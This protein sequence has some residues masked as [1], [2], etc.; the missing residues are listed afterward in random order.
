MRLSTV[1]VV[2]LPQ[3]S[4]SGF[5]P[6][7]P[8]RCIFRIAPACLE[9]PPGSASPPRSTVN[10]H[11]LRSTAPVNG[12]RRGSVVCSHSPS[13]VCQPPDH[14]PYVIKEIE[15]FF[16]CNLIDD[17]GS[18]QDLQV[19][20]DFPGRPVGDPV[21]IHPSPPCSSVA[22]RQIGRH[23][24]GR[25]DHLVLEAPELSR[26]LVDEYD[27]L[28]SRPDR[29]VESLEIAVG[30]DWDGVLRVHTTLPSRR[31]CPLSGIAKRPALAGLSLTGGGPA[32]TGA[33][34]H[35]EHH[36]RIVPEK[37]TPLD[38]AFRAVEG[39]SDFREPGPL[40]ETVDCARDRDSTRHAVERA[41]PT[42]NGHRRLPTATAN[43]NIAAIGP[44]AVTG[45]GS[46]AGLHRRS[47][48][49]RRFAFRQ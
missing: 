13:R 30:N 9:A 42:D 4:D 21:V 24:R 6:A 1:A 12:Y 10:R 35:E 40:A 31:R 43:G 15:G 38:I 29:D 32:A 5:R 23:R 49:V 48:T 16:G 25:P 26:Y 8:P 47:I 7:S 41:R 44:E 36:Q 39:V 27:R 17:S 28:A 20:V 19:D 14:C 2:A 45:S 34:E 46:V 3:C 37:F 22:F 11:G 18:C 33:H